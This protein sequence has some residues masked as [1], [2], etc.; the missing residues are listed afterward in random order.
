VTLN[1]LQAF[2]LVARLGSLTAAAR[3][4][5]VTEP[6]VAAALAALRRQFGDPL[7][8]RGP[9]G[10]VLTAGGRRLVQIASQMVAL[11]VEAEEAIRQA[12]GAPE[13]LRVVA[14]ASVAESSGP[15]LLDAFS[16]RAGAVEVSLAVVQAGDM[17]TLLLERL[18]D[19]ALGPRLAADDAPELESVPL[20]R[21]RL[22]VVAAPTHPL[23]RRQS[24]GPRDVA[25]QVWL[26]DPGATDP[27]GVA[28]GVLRR[29]GVSDARI[30]VFPSQAATHLAAEE[31]RGVALTL[32]HVV[33][34]EVER[35]AL[36]VLKVAGFPLEVLWFATML[37]SDRR[38]PVVASFR[39]F[40]SKP[41]AT[42]AMHTVSTGRPLGRFRPPVHVTIWS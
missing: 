11:A 18:V 16:A 39:H 21:P 10:M 35:G 41:A 37:R 32:A 38:S 25:G 3:S 19:V 30:E 26:V 9:G 24:V 17:A 14:D 8:E 5:G 15:A 22:V 33:A 12:N 6:A 31:G 1:Q 13:R 27:A 40:L 2:V 34:A 7:V 23:A 36:S 4:L 29:L 28:F 42:H 20:L